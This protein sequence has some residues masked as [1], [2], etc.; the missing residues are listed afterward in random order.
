[1]Q[2]VGH[3]IPGI[4]CINPILRNENRAMNEAEIEK[5]QFDVRVIIDDAITSLMLARLHQTNSI[6]IT[7]DPISNQDG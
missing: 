4:R 2:A 1:M 3:V 5:R 7:H 6:E